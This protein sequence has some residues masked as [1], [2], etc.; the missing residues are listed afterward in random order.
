[1]ADISQFI[2]SDIPCDDNQDTNLNLSITRSIENGPNALFAAATSTDCPEGMTPGY[3]T[4][5]L[6]I[7]RNGVSETFGPYESGTF[8]A[9]LTLTGGEIMTL[10]GTLLDFQ[11]TGD[12]GGLYEIETVYSAQDECENI[13]TV[14]SSAN[15]II[16]VPCDE[17][18]TTINSIDC[19][20]ISAVAIDIS[21][22]NTG[23]N[24]VINIVIQNGVGT[25]LN[26][27]PATG[28]SYVQTLDLTVA[29][30]NLTAGDSI[31]VLASSSSDDCAET[32]QQSVNCTSDALL[33]AT[34]DFLS[35]TNGD[36]TGDP[37]SNALTGTGNTDGDFIRHQIIDADG[38]TILNDSGYL[39]HTGG[40]NESYTHTGIT[41]SDDSYI[42][43]CTSN[44]GPL[45]GTTS[46]TDEVCDD[47]HIPQTTIANLDGSDP[48]AVTFDVSAVN[49]DPDPQIQIT[50]LDDVGA[51]LGSYVV[52]GTSSSETID[53]TAA[54]YNY[55]GSDFR[56]VAES[57]NDAS[58][59]PSPI[60]DSCSELEPAEAVYAANAP[61]AGIVTDD[62]DLNIVGVDLSSSLKDSSDP[63]FRSSR[64]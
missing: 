17:P 31:I 16:P 53:L 12:Q 29:P 33:N 47:C 46:A 27:I 9:S 36:G 56:I 10:T 64:F 55:V 60:N 28:T 62:S 63:L 44:I 3:P 45:G 23:T 25:T 40:A 13:E 34:F 59:T 35:D 26:T 19:A 54:P 22:V 18:I 51:V 61:L 1:M 39:D 32:T 5:T 42:R 30:Y 2:N 37:I 43:I 15:I 57:F 11:I 48:T 38:T 6:N 14:S 52:G 21:A 41:L 49:V 50:V 4:L 20:D 7:T 24:P 8:P 58:G